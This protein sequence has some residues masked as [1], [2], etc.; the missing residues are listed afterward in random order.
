M[1]KIEKIF[2]EIDEI[3][4]VIDLYRIEPLFR[5]EKNRRQNKIISD[6]R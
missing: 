5:E 4:K 1:P 6:E 3:I 2:V